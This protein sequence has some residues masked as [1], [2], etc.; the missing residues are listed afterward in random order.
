M[1]KSE[2]QKTPCSVDR[3]P[4]CPAPVV[5]EAVVMGS[6]ITDLFM[7]CMSYPV[8]FYDDLEQNN[9]PMVCGAL[10]MASYAYINGRTR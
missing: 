8:N 2:K 5:D 3:I 4:L 7:S 6:R 9:V 1:L 10:T